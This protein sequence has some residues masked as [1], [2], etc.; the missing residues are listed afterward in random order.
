MK[1]DKQTPE[2]VAADRAAETAEEPVLKPAT[3]RKLRKLGWIIMP[4]GLLMMIGG[5]AVQVYIYFISGGTD[6]TRHPHLM[7]WAGIIA[8][9]GIIMLVA[10]LG[11]RL[12]GSFKAEEESVDK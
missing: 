8:T 7:V 12:T 11:M 5:S 3:K 2:Q 4:L 6:T 9:I 10:G 1:E